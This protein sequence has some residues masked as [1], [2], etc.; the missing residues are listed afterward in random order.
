MTA[1]IGVDQRADRHVGRYVHCRQKLGSA[2]ETDGGDRC[3]SL[4][5]DVAGAEIGAGMLDV[6]AIARLWFVV[7]EC[8]RVYPSMAHVELSLRTFTLYNP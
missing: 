3:D 4:I 1:A 6:V 5:D 7:H 2:F 8:F